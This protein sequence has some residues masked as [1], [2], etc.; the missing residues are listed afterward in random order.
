MWKWNFICWVLRN[1]TSR[2]LLMHRLLR[3]RETVERELERVGDRWITF[4][5]RLK[6]PLPPVKIA[7]TAARVGVV[8]QGKVMTHEDFTLRSVEHYRHTFPG[9]PIFVSTWK[10]ESRAVLEALEKAGA[11]LLVND[12]PELP[13]PTHLNY[14]IRSTL[15]GIEAARA[16]GCRYVLKTRTDARMYA[17][18]IPD[19]L[20]GLIHQFPIRPGLSANGRLV[21]LDWA[22][23][24]FIPHHPADLMMFGYVEDIARYWDVPLCESTEIVS[25]PTFTRFSELLNPLLPEVYLCRNYLRLLDYA[26]EPTIASWWQ[27][28]ADLFVVVDRT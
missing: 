26:F 10:D 18:N 13:G 9:C 24:L 15:A 17:P 3:L 16:A 5:V 22:T 6:T 28:L 21:I 25:R 11:V 12:A 14:Q 4:N 20:A 19:F 7:T 1:F 8:I 2:K 27:C 23:R